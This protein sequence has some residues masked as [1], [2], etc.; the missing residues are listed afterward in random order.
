MD[1]AR[2]IADHAAQRTA[3]VGRGIGTE[4]Q[5]VP[6]S[7]VAQMIENQT[8]LHTRESSLSIQFKDAVHIL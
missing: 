1:A 7:R 4:G 2:I 3:I 6:L 5:V 8:G